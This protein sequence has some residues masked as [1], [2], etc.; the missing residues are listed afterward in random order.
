M[1]WLG[2]VGELNDLLRHLSFND[3]SGREVDAEEGFSEWTRWTH[4]VRDLERTIYLI[5]NGASASMASHFAADLAK[6][7]HLHTQVFSDLSLNQG[8]YK[9]LVA[10]PLPLPGKDA[11]TSGRR[12]LDRQA[13]DDTCRSQQ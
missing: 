13:R 1:S 2:M 3:P 6:N 11:P 10:V 4:Q 5:G 7:G 9:A 12:R 8:V